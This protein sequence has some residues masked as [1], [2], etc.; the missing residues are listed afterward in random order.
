MLLGAG[1]SI[2]V[3]CGCKSLGFPFSA[4]TPT[5]PPDSEYTNSLKPQHF[6]GYHDRQAKKKVGKEKTKPGSFP[7]G[8][9]APSP[10]TPTSPPAIA[11][12]SQGHE[13]SDQTVSPT[14]DLKQRLTCSRKHEKNRGEPKIKI[15]TKVLFLIFLKAWQ[16]FRIPN[17]ECQHA[18]AD[19]K[20]RLS[21]E[22]KNDKTWI[23][24]I[25]TNLTG[26]ILPL[27][28]PAKPPSRNHPWLGNWFLQHKIIDPWQLQSMIST[29]H[30]DQELH[31]LLHH[32]DLD[33]E[34]EH[35]HLHHLDLDLDHE[36]HHLD[37]DHLL[38]LSCLPTPHEE[39][40]LLQAPK[41]PDD[42][43]WFSVLTIRVQS[44]PDTILRLVRPSRW[45]ALDDHPSLPAAL[46]GLVCVQPTPGSDGHS[47]ITL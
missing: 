46:P 19:S 41:D 35:H 21:V 22:K 6:E 28:S 11:S 25:L 10:S 18:S 47:W 43:L 32:I 39:E 37:L 40:Q 7:A 14:Q 20:F 38:L 36:H 2:L 42:N 16:W 45:R 4:H 34:E 23:F 13:L 29:S 12:C 31:H 30:V 27:S 15:M 24:D 1:R 8:G 3:A 33:Q 5:H 17:F 44:T 26:S 9:R